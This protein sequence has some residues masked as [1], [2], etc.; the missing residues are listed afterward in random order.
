MSNVEKW[1]FV[2]F[3]VFLFKHVHLWKGT[4]KKAVKINIDYHEWKRSLQKRQFNV[5]WKCNLEKLKFWFHEIHKN[6][7]NLNLYF[8]ILQPGPLKMRLRKSFNVFLFLQIFL[9]NFHDFVHL[10]LSSGSFVSL[11][12]I[13]LVVFT[14]QSPQEQKK[15]LKMNIESLIYKMV[16]RFYSICNATILDGLNCLPKKWHSA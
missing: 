8:L 2:F 15:E 14:Y 4:L 9:Q 7:L 12:R 13:F 10:K 5:T 1:C 16:F 6:Q 11:L 3:I